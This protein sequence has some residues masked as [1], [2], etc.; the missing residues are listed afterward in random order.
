[1]LLSAPCSNQYP[2]TYH[3]V[4]YEKKCLTISICFSYRHPLLP[5]FQVQANNTNIEPGSTISIPFTVTTTTN[6][7]VNDTATG[8][9]TVRANNDRSYA[10]TSPSTVTVAAGSEGKANGTVT[11]TVPAS[12][13]SGTDVTLTIEA[14]NAAATDINYAVLRFSVAAKV[15]EKDKELV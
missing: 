5:P 13:A 3:L 10:S 2:S 9:L 7:V 11:F 1:M 6:G 4:Q 8:T 14:E 15:R 12:A